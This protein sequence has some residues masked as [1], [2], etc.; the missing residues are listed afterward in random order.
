MTVNRKTQTDRQVNLTNTYFLCMGTSL[1][2]RSVKKITDCD[3][4]L[5]IETTIPYYK[6][7]VPVKFQLE[8]KKSVYLTEDMRTSIS[9]NN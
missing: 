3:F 6:S 2:N 4:L 7:S 8:T 5:F 9:A 1:G